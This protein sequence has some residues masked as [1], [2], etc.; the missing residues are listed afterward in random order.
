[1]LVTVAHPANH[2]G[3]TALAA[4]IARRLHFRPARSRPRKPATATR[5]RARIARAGQ[6]PRQRAERVR[7]TAILGFLSRR[8]ERPLRRPYRLRPKAK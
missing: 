8:R 1:M 3:C 5:S 6:R 7:L 2:A 4:E